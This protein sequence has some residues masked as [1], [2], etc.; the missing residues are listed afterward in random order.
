MPYNPQELIGKFRSSGL[1]QTAFCKKNSLPHSTLHYYLRRSAKD[2]CLRENDARFI[3]VSLPKPDVAAPCAIAFVR[4]C[5]SAEQIAA[6]IRQVA[7]E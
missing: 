4:G 3:P 7:E 1:T 6:L 5:F 2:T